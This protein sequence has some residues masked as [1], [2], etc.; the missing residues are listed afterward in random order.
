MVRARCAPRH[1]YRRLTAVTDETEGHEGDET[2]RLPGPQEPAWVK[3][4]ALIVGMTALIIGA[5]F[6]GRYTGTLGN[7]RACSEVQK[8]YEDL[9]H[10]TPGRDEN[11]SF[12]IRMHLVADHPNCFPADLVAAAKA[13]LDYAPASN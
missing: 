5:F 12:R 10:L 13:A 8:S 9:K 1:S 11:V 7:A 2:P 4:T 3:R 6:L